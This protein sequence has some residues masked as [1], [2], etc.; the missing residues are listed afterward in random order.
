MN[1][2]RSATAAMVAIRKKRE[3]LRSSSRTRQY[4][5]MLQAPGMSARSKLEASSQ[6]PEAVVLQG[7]TLISLQLRMD[8][9]HP[10]RTQFF[11][12]PDKPVGS[13]CEGCL[14]CL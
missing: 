14:T 3:C 5:R 7:L 11:T 8:L 2:R 10:W 13:D 1:R 9:T 4:S 6:K 12:I